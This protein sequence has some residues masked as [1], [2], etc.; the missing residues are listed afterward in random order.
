MGGIVIAKALCLAER[1]TSLYPDM[2]ECIAGC[3]FFGTPFNGAPV[4]EIADYWAKI[5]EK[6]G[7]AVNSQLLE[8]LKPGNDS[9]RELKR[10]FVEA[11]GKLMQKVE[12]L[13]F[14]EQMMTNWD[15]LIQKLASQEFPPDLLSKLDSKVCQVKALIMS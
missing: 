1:Q 2:Y 5:N 11:S 7:I 6:S 3:V 8:L 14:Y 9:L 4:A 10:D 13:C 15:D 12:L